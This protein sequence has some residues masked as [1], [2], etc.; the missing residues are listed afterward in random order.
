[1]LKLPEEMSRNACQALQNRGCLAELLRR[2]V[3]VSAARRG[4]RK[5][6]RLWRVARDDAIKQGKINK[7]LGIADC[8][9][10]G[11]PPLATGN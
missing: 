11:S 1:M 4:S 3:R 7:G 8:I 9:S 2:R 5:R 10:A 6:R